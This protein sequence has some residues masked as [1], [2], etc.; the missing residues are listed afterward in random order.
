MKKKK[1]LLF[2]CNGWELN[3]IPKTGILDSS[4]T[5]SWNFDVGD[6]ILG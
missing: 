4:L 6:K 1:I 2:G 3:R 5:S